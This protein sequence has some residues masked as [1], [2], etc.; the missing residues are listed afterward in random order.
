[1]TYRALH[2]PV[3]DEGNNI[4]GDRSDGLDFQHIFGSGHLNFF[5]GLSTR[6]TRRYISLLSPSVF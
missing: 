4:V 5:D 3:F 2:A 6:L 1:M